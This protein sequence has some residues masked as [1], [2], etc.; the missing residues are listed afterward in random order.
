[1]HLRESH[2]SRRRPPIANASSQVS[3]TGVGAVV[4]K[5]SVPGSRINAVCKFSY[6]PAQIRRIQ[7]G[8]LAGEAGFSAKMLRE[9]VILLLSDLNSVISASCSVC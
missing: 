7:D 9:P 3:F 6:R 5:A 8:L 2:A 4:A 1:M